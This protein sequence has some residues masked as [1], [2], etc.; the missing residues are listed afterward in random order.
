MHTSDS[1]TYVAFR[2]QNHIF[3]SIYLVVFCIKTLI[4]SRSMHLHDIQIFEMLTSKSVCLSR[5][6]HR[7]VITP[8]AFFRAKLVF[9]ST[10]FF[11]LM[12]WMLFRK[13]KHAWGKSILYY[14]HACTHNSIGLYVYN[15]YNASWPEYQRARLRSTLR[16]RRI[17]MR[18]SA[19]LSHRSC[20]LATDWRTDR[21]AEAYLLDI[22]SRQTSYVE[23]A[24]Q[25]VFSHV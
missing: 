2:L 25:G 8:R 23:S 11:F 10:S 18:E 19:R 6:S 1:R 9:S 20:F 22:T 14:Y 4:R 15:R 12:A 5:L 16:I 3:F 17:C 13:D 7:R 21:Q 24:R